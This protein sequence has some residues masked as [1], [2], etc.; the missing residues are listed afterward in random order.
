[1]PDERPARTSWPGGG[2]GLPGILDRVRERLWFWPTVLGALAIL[3]AEALVRADRALEDRPAWVFGGDAQAARS[4]LTTI[5]TSTMT[6]L[7]VTL[8]I[9]LA[10][11]ALTAQGYSP[12]A[13][14]RFMRDRLIQVV[15]G[16]FV[17]TFLFSLVALRLVRTD[18]VPGM[19][20]TVAVVLA[21]VA[22]ALLIAFFHHL[23]SE[24]RAERVIAA[25]WEETVAE[26]QERFPEPLAGVSP[27]A[28][29]GA[30]VAVARATGTGRVRGI[31]LPAL[32]DVAAATGGRADVVPGPGDF[33]A[34]GEPVVT[35]HGGGRPDE[36][37]SARLAAAVRLGS[38]RALA[39]DVAFGLRQL[40]DVGLRALSP[41]IN[42]PT[43]A[44]DAILRA[45]DI[46][47]RLA[48]RRLDRAVVRDGRVLA[49]LGRPTWDELVRIVFAQPTAGAEL[50]ADAAT[51]RTLADALG[52]V[53][54]AT[55]APD[56]LETLRG[57]ARRLDA[58]ARRALPD[59]EDRRAVA[60][61][62]AH[63]A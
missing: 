50:Q 17:A 26:A 16:G 40:T 19:T 23:A 11:L 8:T 2:S 14:R 1:M 31:D 63:L 20:V 42:D 36:A 6:V 24:I 13:L 51:M 47:R 15:I 10:V 12:R 59:E 21:A 29:D 46:L 55:D 41:G 7:G 18:R 58:A 45:A 35:L 3:G 62:L 28:P 34:R 4:V 49:V 39:C 32:A 57:A 33:V 44:H 48:D 37:A 52:R 9:T 61:L 56:R 54:A 53:A 22:V 43:T 25:I 5:A 60:G 30:A 27:G 38:D